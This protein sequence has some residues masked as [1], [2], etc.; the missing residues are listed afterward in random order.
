MKK[1]VLFLALA[2]MMSVSAMAQGSDDA[3]QGKWKVGISLGGNSN[4]YQMST[5]Y[6]A[7]WKQSGRGGA[8]IGLVGQYD[9]YE[10]L[11]VRAELQM[12]EKNYRN[13]R[14]LITNDYRYTNS[15]LQMP[16]MASFSFGGS[17][18]RGFANLG[19][20]GGYWMSSSVEVRTFN[21]II[22]R[23]QDIEQ[24]DMINS[25]RDNRW[26]FGYVAGAGIEYRFSDRWAAQAEARYY[27]DA[28]SQVKQYQRISDHRYNTTI[29]VQLAAMY[30]F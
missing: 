25:E 6:Q 26:V 3:A 10:W 17:K 14:E 15:Y 12:I 20:Y 8:S 29:G 27:W 18:L 28:T 11:G 24:D 16:V 22:D 30:T 1:K 23:Y 13:S 7:D 21:G 4:F 9:F 19:I 2:A 5:S